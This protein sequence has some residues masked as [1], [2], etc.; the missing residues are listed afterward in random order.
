MNNITAYDSNERHQAFMKM[1]LRAGAEN[2]RRRYVPPNVYAAATATPRG[3]FSSAG[4]MPGRNLH[5][6]AC[7][8]RYVSRLQMQA[9][10]CH[11][12]ACALQGWGQVMGKVSGYSGFAGSFSAGGRGTI[13][14]PV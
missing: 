8:V 14:L 13:C 12:G 4:E 3:Q 6:R 1:R 10:M 5:P 11:A 7:G 2:T 9:L